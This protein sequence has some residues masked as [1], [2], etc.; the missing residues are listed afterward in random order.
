M[1]KNS[2][3]ISAII[4][5]NQTKNCGK[6]YEEVALK[7]TKQ[8]FSGY[9]EVAELLIQMGANVNTLGNRR[10]TAL[11]LATEKGNFKYQIM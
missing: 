8:F 9:D 6:N 10:N 11:T 5:G 7:K 2:A 4:E 1:L 3:L